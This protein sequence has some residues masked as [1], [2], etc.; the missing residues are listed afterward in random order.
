MWQSYGDGERQPK[1]TISLKCSSRGQDGWHH[2]GQDDW[3]HET[4]SLLILEKA[5]FT[6]AK[7]TGTWE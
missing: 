6:V 7:C 4:H 5:G 3:H 2:G 1:V